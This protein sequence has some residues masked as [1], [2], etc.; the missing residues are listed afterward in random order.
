[1]NLSETK[2]NITQNYGGRGEEGES[3]KATS[4][5]VIHMIG[6]EKVAGGS[7]LNIYFKSLGPQMRKAGSGHGHSNQY[8]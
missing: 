5:V 8:L 2:P 6:C 3:L 4:E 1:M 7:S